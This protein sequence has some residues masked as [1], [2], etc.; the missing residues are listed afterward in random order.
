[1]PS[2]WPHWGNGSCLTFELLTSCPKAQG[3][4]PNSK[5]EEGPCCEQGSVLNGEGLNNR[6]YA[7]FLYCAQ[8]WPHCLQ[9]SL[10][11]YTIVI[12]PNWWGHVWLALKEDFFYHS[13]LSFSWSVSGMASVKCAGYQAG[14]IPRIPRV[15]QHTEF[16]WHFIPCGLRGVWL[17]VMQGNTVVAFLWAGEKNGMAPNRVKRCGKCG[18]G[19]VFKVRMWQRHS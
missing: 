14:S 8:V 16:L 9:S 3:W 12:F 5:L 18:V 11:C 1:M 19:L 17:I 4:P 6:F 15:V 10:F 2:G 7:W 13:H